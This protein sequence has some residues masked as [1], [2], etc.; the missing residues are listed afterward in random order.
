MSTPNL[1]RK[2]RKAECFL[3]ENKLDKARHL[4]N[5]LDDDF[6]HKH[7]LLA[8]LGSA[9]GDFASATMHLAHALTCTNDQ[10]LLSLY[11]NQLLGMRFTVRGLELQGLEFSSP[12]S[13]VSGDRRKKWLFPDH[14]CYE[15]ELSPDILSRLNEELSLY[16]S[17]ELGLGAWESI[18]RDDATSAPSKP[19]MDDL[20]GNRG[21]ASPRLGK[22][23]E[24][25]SFIYNLSCFQGYVSLDDLQQNTVIE[26]D[27]GSVMDYAILEPGFSRG[28]FQHILE[29]GGGYGRFAE[30]I[31]RNSPKPPTSY[32]LIDAIPSSI[33]AAYSYLRRNLPNV[34]VDILWKDSSIKPESS[35]GI[36]LV[37]AWNATTLSQCTFDL[38]V[39][40]ESMQEMSSEYVNYWIRFVDERA[41]ES[42]IIY[43]S[44]S[45][46]YVN[47]LNMQYPRSW[48]NIWM[49]DTPR[50]WTHDHPAIAFRKQLLDRESDIRDDLVKK[51][52]LK[53]VIV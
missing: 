35:A 49:T 11:G 39:N 30:A 16:N 8:C 52:K 5:G 44:N 6:S 22:T 20:V 38:A 15:T 19:R 9:C 43:L 26:A 48:K 17:A 4:I 24:Y 2:V 21:M 34:K 29:I 10:S 23:I 47:P 18:A 12:N 37:P 31:Y 14:A 25:L 36:L 27:L 50:G 28:D 40:I 3:R 1:W 45:R 51:W 7:Y 41:I 13:M 53:Q 32:I 46:V 42:S 33:A